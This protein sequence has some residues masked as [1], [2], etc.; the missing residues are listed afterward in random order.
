MVCC[1]SLLLSML[2]ESRK[3]FVQSLA[4]RVALGVISAGYSRVF[5]QSNESVGF[6]AGDPLFSRK[7]FCKLQLPQL[8]SP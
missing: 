8:L 1:K 4:P 6:P 7:A 2:M 3:L 5:V